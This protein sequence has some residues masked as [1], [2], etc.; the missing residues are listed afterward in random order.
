M[1][2]WWMLTISPSSAYGLLR[3]LRLLDRLPG[4][5][6]TADLAGEMRLAV[7]GA[8]TGRARLEVPDDALCMCPL[9]LPVIVAGG[10]GFPV[11]AHN[12]CGY[13]TVPN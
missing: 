13:G 11:D 4:I 12:G 2:L 9:E 5:A 3:W 7:P 10:S 1:A 6:G 8:L